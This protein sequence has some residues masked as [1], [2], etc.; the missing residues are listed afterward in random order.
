VHPEYRSTG[1]GPDLIRY[2]DEQLRADGCQAVYHHV[3]AA[4]NFGP[5]LKRMGYEL[6]DLIYAKRLDKE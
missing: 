4:H 1:A 5:L 6:V 2:C 3:K